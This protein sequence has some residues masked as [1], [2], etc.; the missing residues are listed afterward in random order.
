MIG[1]V[2]GQGVIWYGVFAY[3]DNDFG[4]GSE[5]HDPLLDASTAGQLKQL[6]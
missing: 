4:D 1:N 2:D 5:S 3:I 6:F